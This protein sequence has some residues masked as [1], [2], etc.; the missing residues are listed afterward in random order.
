M[1][2]PRNRDAGSATV[3]VEEYPQEVVYHTVDDSYFDDAVFIGDSPDV[4][5]YR[6]GRLERHPRFILPPDNREKI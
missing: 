4:G 1:P 6:C 3:P 5:M 2:E